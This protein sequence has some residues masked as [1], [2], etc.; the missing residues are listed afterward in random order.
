MATLRNLALGLFSIHGI[1]KIKQTVQA[2]GRNPLRALPLVTLRH[3]QRS[4]TDF[5][6]ACPKRSPMLGAPGI[7][8][9]GVDQ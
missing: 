2:I 5:E 6:I 4:A 1:T 9:N 8:L 3:A 7:D